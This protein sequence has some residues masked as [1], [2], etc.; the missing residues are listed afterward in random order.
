MPWMWPIALAS[1]EIALVAGRSS[2]SCL[3]MFADGKIHA[4]RDTKR[5]QGFASSACVRFR[6]AR[7]GGVKSNVATNSLRYTT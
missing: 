1:F 4:A 5:A 6:D 2:Y 7:L 3:L